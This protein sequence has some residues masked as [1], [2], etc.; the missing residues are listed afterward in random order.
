LPDSFT[1][2]SSP[3]NNN[4]KHIQ[5]KKARR[6]PDQCSPNIWRIQEVCDLQR[7]CLWP[8]SLCHYEEQSDEAISGTETLRCLLASLGVSTQ[9]D[10]S[11]WDC[12]A[13]PAM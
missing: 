10:T 8:S 13:S 6:N 4:Q 1:S 7:R 11:G 12:F 2:L 9:G 5:A 3:H